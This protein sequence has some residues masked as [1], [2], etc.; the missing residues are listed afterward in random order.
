MQRG[1][2]GKEKKGEKALNKIKVNPW[3]KFQAIP[4]LTLSVNVSL[5]LY[6]YLSA[7]YLDR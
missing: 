6:I 5:F 7:L 3:E 1:L 2:E 4:T